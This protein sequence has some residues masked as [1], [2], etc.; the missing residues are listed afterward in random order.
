MME[1]TR[2]WAEL[3]AEMEERDNATGLRRVRNKTVDGFY[4]VRRG[5][6]DGPRNARRQVKWAWQRVFRGWDDR[7]VWSLDTHLARTLGAQL[8]MMADIAHGYPDGFTFETWTAALRLHGGALTTYS[9]QWDWDGTTDW[10]EI[11]LPA[12]DALRWIADNFATLWD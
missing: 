9:E 11:Y 4:T 3:T 2:S 1:N 7:V 5:L 12:Q 6:R 10:D 8:V